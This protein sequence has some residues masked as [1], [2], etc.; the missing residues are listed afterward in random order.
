MKK[1]KIYCFLVAALCFGYLVLIHPVLKEINPFNFEYP[2]L[3]AGVVSGNILLPISFYLWKKVP[4]T[5]RLFS[6]DVPVFFAG[7]AF[8]GVINLILSCGFVVFSFCFFGIG[9][10]FCHYVR[11]KLI[12]QEKEDSMRDSSVKGNQKLTPFAH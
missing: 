9:W 3:V 2:L 11:K 4:T 10:Y 7:V 5:R 6:K 12:L 8:L 1:K